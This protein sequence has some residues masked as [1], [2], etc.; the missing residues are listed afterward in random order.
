MAWGVPVRIGVQPEHCELEHGSGNNDGE[1][2][3][4]RIH[5]Q[6]KH[7]ELERPVCGQY[8]LVVN[9]VVLV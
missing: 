9:S 4:F 7:R 2:V 5:V 8:A 1:R 3:R 6:P